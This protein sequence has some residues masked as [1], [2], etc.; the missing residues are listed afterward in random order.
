ML[1]HGT[2]IEKLTVVKLPGQDFF[3]FRNSLIIIACHMPNLSSGDRDWRFLNRLFNFY[4]SYLESFFI[5]PRYHLARIYAFTTVSKGKINRMGRFSTGVLPWQFR[6]QLIWRKGF[7]V[8][9]RLFSTDSFA[10]KSKISIL[11]AFLVLSKT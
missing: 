11:P 3:P 5:F 7:L 10:P 1:R 4:L 9:S 2:L 6:R 8:E